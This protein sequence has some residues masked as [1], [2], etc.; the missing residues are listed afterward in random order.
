MFGRALYRIAEQ[1]RS[2]TECG[3]KVNGFNKLDN[4]VNGVIVAVIAALV[5]RALQRP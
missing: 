4:E 5:D 3:A 2:W 1:I